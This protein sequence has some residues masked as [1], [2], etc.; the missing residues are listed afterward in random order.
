MSDLKCHLLPEL[1]LLPQNVFLP[2]HP[3]RGW[4]SS[5]PGTDF[6]CAALQSSENPTD[7]CDLEPGFGVGEP[8]VQS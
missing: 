5:L 8:G 4:R 3:C 2:L 7:L 6:M 1:F